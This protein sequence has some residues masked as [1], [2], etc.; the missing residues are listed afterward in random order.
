MEKENE[1]KEEYGFFDWEEQ[2]PSENGKRDMQNLVEIRR[3][4]PIATLFLL[5]MG[6]GLITLGSCLLY[7]IFL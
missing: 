7:G 1:I 5:C 4:N 3:S 2:N 6:G